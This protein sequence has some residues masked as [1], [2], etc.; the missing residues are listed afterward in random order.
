VQKKKIKEKEKYAATAE[1]LPVILG[2]IA[3]DISRSTPPGGGKSSE[4]Q[5]N[6]R[7]SSSRTE[8][9]HTSITKTLTLNFDEEICRV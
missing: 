4:F 2:Q 8:E 7:L 5:R 6:L 9:S 3:S 1:V